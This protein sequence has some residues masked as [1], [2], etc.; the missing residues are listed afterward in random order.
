VPTA[1]MTPCC[2]PTSSASSE[3]DVSWRVEGALLE[4]SDDG[5][6]VLVSS[7]D[8]LDRNLTWFAGGTGLYKAVRPRERTAQRHCVCLS[9]AHRRRWR[10]GPSATG[11]MPGVT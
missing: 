10:C 8:H 2:S 4:Q 9:G 7:P 11:P 6:Q 3:V 1:T 5:H